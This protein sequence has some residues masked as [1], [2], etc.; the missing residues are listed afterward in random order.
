MPNPSHDVIVVGAGV[1]GLSIAW[2]LQ[3][4]GRQVLLLDSREAGREASWAGGGILTPITPQAY[5]APLVSLCSQSASL[6]PQF[7][8]ELEA[9]SGISAELRDTGLLRISKRD[10]GSLHEI[11]ALHASLGRSVASIDGAAARRIE[12]QLSPE[13]KSA[14]HEPAIRQVRNPRLLRALVLACIASGVELREHCGVESLRLSDGR[15]RGVQVRGELIRSRET[16]IAAGAWSGSLAHSIG[17]ELPVSPV[18]GDMLL[19]ETQ[20]PLI[21]SIIIHEGH[22]LI[23]RADGRLIV[24]STTIERGFD[25]RVLAGAIAELLAAAIGMVPAIANCAWSQAWAGL[26]PATPDRLPYLGRPKGVD[27]LILATGHYRN[28]LSLAPVTAA[29]VRELLTDQAPSVDLSP[30]RPDRLLA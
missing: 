1:V 9:A 27:G 4:S 7:V 18:H 23:P 25:K 11:A 16:I 2:E 30:F 12:P 10:D 22:Y 17:L 14:L 15:V 5:P 21:S 13:L 26:R 29:I 24:G 19:F 20:P 8:A 3:R 6:Y 28:G